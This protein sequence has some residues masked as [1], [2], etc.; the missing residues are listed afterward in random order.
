[1]GRKRS[2]SCRWSHALFAV[3]TFRWMKIP[4]QAPSWNTTEKGCVSKKSSARSSSR[5]RIR[6]LFNNPGSAAADPR[7]APVLPSVVVLHGDSSKPTPL[8][9]Q[10]SFSTALKGGVILL[11]PRQVIYT[12]MTI[13][14][15]S[16]SPSPVLK[17]NPPYPPLS[18]G[19]KKAMRPRR[20]E[21]AL[22]FLTPLTRGV[23]FAPYGL[24]Q[25]P[26]K[27]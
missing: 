23:A 1:M 15:P 21:G 11:S 2:P 10:E 7:Y 3:S 6:G 17:T 4:P 5:L 9:R 24:L 22:L 16:R 8:P 19:Y 18:G 12:G 25:Q 26:G 20:A 27:G 14:T 13:K